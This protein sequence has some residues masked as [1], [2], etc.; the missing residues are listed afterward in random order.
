MWLSLDGQ[1]SS[2]RLVGIVEEIGAAGVAYVT[3]SAFARATGTTGRA[4]LFRISTRAQSATD[5]QN[6]IRA[7]DQAITSAGVEVLTP[8]SELRTAVGDHV[9]ILIRALL[10]MAIVMAVVGSLGLGSTLGISVVERTRELGVMKALGATPARVARLI[11][12]E[13]AWINALS[14]ALS[15]SVSLPLT[16]GV[17]QLVGNLG[18]L[19][20]LPLVI[21][22]SPALIWLVLTAV[23]GL[24]ATWL[25]ARRAAAL[26]VKE[27]LSCN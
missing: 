10:A 22:L 27:A 6:A 21:G 20:P 4:R 2:W 24:A 14:F 15:L 11:I 26:T 25:P 5:R 12:A 1:S 8:L 23:V 17:D 9:V 3:D 18:F 16:F 19:A 7:I 13:S